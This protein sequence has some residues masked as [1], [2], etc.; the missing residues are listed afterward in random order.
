MKNQR[1]KKAK[2][3][4]LAL[5]CCTAVYLHEE[6]PGFADFCADRR[7]SPKIITNS[8]ARAALFTAD[9]VIIA[10]IAGTNDYKDWKNN[11]TFKKRSYI[12][13]GKVSSGFGAHFGLIR[14]PLVAAIAEEYS[15]R[16]RPL[17][18]CGHS[19]GGACTYLLELICRE[20]GILPDL[21][22]VAGAPRPGDADF[23]EQIRNAMDGR[24]IQLRNKADLVPCLPPWTMGYRHPEPGV[25]VITLRG[26]I[27]PGMNPFFQQLQR[28]GRTT[29]GHISFRGFRLGKA[30][31]I[32]DHSIRQY[33]RAVVASLDSLKPAALKWTD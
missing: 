17:I 21:V 18:L 23:A 3:T 15:R 32:H 9:N 22:V 6:G 27:K 29:A 8:N 26:A 2:Q 1:R 12:G 20:K 11:L 19:L 14:R 33:H 24:L 31:S 10:C 13:K 7:L 25:S 4:E 28:I 16:P 5:A 30:V